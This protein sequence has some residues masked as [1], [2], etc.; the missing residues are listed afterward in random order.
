MEEIL[1]DAED[2]GVISAMLNGESF[3]VEGGKGILASEFL[4]A[5]L[6]SSETDFL[7]NIYGY[8]LRTIKKT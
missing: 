7:F 2:A 4:K 6:E 3:E 1:P 8:G 5:K